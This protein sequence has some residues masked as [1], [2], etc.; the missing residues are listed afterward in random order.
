MVGALD[1]RGTELVVL[2]A[3][4]TAGGSSR[5]GEGILGLVRAFRLAGARNVIASLWPV[6]DAATQL[7]MKLFYER[8]LSK[9]KP[10]PAVALREAAKALREHE[11]TVG[12]KT[13][14]PYEAPRY[15]AAFVVYTRR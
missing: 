9:A 4:D 14:R 5:S 12:D 7:L 2:S 15:W 6:D 13:T 3:C 8:W 1:L 11:V 10:S